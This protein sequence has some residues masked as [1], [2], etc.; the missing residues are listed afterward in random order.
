[1]TTATIT[2]LIELDPATLSD[3]LA[4]QAVT[5]IDVRESGEYAREHISTAQLQPLSAFQARQILDKND[6]PIVLYC[7]TGNRSQQAAKLLLQTNGDRP[8][9]HLVGGLDAWKAADLPYRENKKAPLPIMRQVQI[10]AGSLVLGGTLLSAF[11]SPWFLLLTGCVGAGL[12]FAGASGFCGM[13]IL[14]A[15][16]P[17]NKVA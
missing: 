2:Q 15:K 11:V 13:A 8:I 5:L 1:M 4:H 3:M 17:Y 7:Q 12:L 10:V 6:D 14:L 16:L 9:Y